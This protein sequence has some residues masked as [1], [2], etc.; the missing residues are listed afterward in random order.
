MLGPVLHLKS[1]Q[2]GQSLWKRLQELPEATDVVLKTWL[3][4]GCIYLNGSRIQHG[5]ER[6]PVLSEDLI[7]I[8]TTPKRFPI[9]RLNASALLFENSDLIAIHKPGGVP[10]LPVAS[11]AIENCKHFFESHLHVRLFPLHRLDEGTE[12]VL[13]FG[14]QPEVVKQFHEDS[15]ANR[16]KKYYVAKTRSAVPLGLHTH[17]L[18]KIPGKMQCLLWPEEN[19]K[20]AKLKVNDCK[21]KEDHFQV[22][23]EL[24]TGRTHQIRC[25]LSFLGAPII[26]DRLYGDRLQKSIFQLKASRIC[27][28][29]LDIR[30]QVS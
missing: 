12:G 18:K 8:H 28:R 30:T 26:G 17:Y 1:T 27:W 23:L 25:Q 16:L 24:L 13:M 22:N 3:E 20:L 9:D 14:K 10:S 11:N 5:E 6:T 15:K 7:K 21:Q 19:A 29:D 4:F 2:A